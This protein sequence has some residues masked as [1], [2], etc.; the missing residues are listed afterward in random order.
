[1]A[2]KSFPLF[3]FIQRKRHSGGFGVHSPFAFDLITN[4]I[5][6]DHQFYAFADLKSKAGKNGLNYTASDDSFNRLVFRLIQ[7][8]RPENVL[9]IHSGKG[10]GTL[11]ILAPDKHTR[12]TCIETNETDCSAAETLIGDPD[13]DRVAFAGE[14]ELQSAKKYDAICLHLSE[15]DNITIDQLFSK[16]HEDTFWVIDG[17]KSRNAKQFWKNIVND[18]RTRFTFDMRHSGI[19]FLKSSYYKLNFL[20]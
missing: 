2:R 10:V 14:E 4:T 17:R 11:F 1:M 3:D 5:R 9:E 13:I 15:T 16:S 18:E 8:F 20:I 6:D 12:C 19:V 7:R